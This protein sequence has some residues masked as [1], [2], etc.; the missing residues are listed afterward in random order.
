[1]HTKFYFGKLKGRDH[2]KDVGIDGR[3]AFQ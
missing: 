1:M 2:E 3:I